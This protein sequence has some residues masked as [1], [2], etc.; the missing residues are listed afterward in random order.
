MSYD[1]TMSSDVPDIQRSSS[2]G[3]FMQ[4]KRSTEEKKAQS[5]VRAADLMAQYEMADEDEKEE[6]LIRKADFK[7]MTMPSLG[8]GLGNAQ[9]ALA[10][11]QKAKK[12]AELRDLGLTKEKNEALGRTKAANL[13]SEFESTAEDREETLNRTGSFP[14]VTMPTL[15]SSLSAGGLHKAAFGKTEQPGQEQ[16][17][18]RRTQST[19]TLSRAPSLNQITSRSFDGETT[20]PVK[21]T[22]AQQRI[23][24]ARATRMRII[25]EMADKELPSEVGIDIVPLSQGNYVVKPTT[26]ENPASPRS[27]VPKNTWRPCHEDHLLC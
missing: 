4:R 19:E 5:G 21:K 2:G 26:G 22:R 8:A 7:S 18:F 11:A 23:D 20:K 13:M 3:F 6:T 14:R 10:Q 12:E 17:V 24:L 9:I 25:A 15:G 1:S 27:V 16:E